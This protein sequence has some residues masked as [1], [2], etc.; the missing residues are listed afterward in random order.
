MIAENEI[1]LTFLLQ[2]MAERGTLDKLAFKGEWACHPLLP[3]ASRP[4]PLL[5]ETK[6]G[7]RLGSRPT[8]GKVPAV[9]GCGRSC[10]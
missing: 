1:G 3:F 4:Q 9:F 5:P 6:G 10:R 2:L 7:T 8:A